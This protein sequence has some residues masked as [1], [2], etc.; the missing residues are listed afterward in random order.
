MSIS[1]IDGLLPNFETTIEQ[2]ANTDREWQ[3]AC[4]KSLALV[5]NDKPTKPV[6]AALFFGRSW[7]DVE[8]E[9]VY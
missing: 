6:G 7:L 2:V 3:L 9:G 5:L 8:R 1:E 4:K